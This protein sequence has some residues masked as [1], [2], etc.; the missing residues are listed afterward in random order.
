MKRTRSSFGRLSLLGITLCA[1][2]LGTVHC[3]KKNNNNGGGNMNGPGD[4]SHRPTVDLRDAL[5]LLSTDT[6]S[7]TKLALMKRH[8]E[9]VEKLK[10]PVPKFDAVDDENQLAGL[11]LADVPFT[12]DGDPF[13][14]PGDEQPG[15]A[16]DAAATTGTG[17]T[18]GTSSASTPSSSGQLQKI[19]KTSGNIETAMTDSADNSNNMGGGKQALPKIITIAVSPTNDLYLQFDQAFIYRDTSGASNAYDMASG[20]QCQIFHV[21]GGTLSQLM[22]SAPS[23]E[24]LECIDNMHFINSW[25]TSS[26]QVFQF[27]AD[28][29]VYYPGTLP[30]GGKT[31]VYKLKRGGPYDGSATTEV[32]NAEVCVQDFM[33][34][35]LGGVFYTGNTCTGGNNMGGG[36]NSGYFRYVAPGANASLVDIA[37]DWYQFIFNP[38]IDS[39]NSVKYDYASFFGPDPT[40]GTTP[41]WGDACLF[42]FDSSQKTAATRTTPL[43]SCGASNDIWSW[44]QMNRPS[45]IANYG[46]N[47]A[48]FGCQGCGGCQFNAATSV[49]NKTGWVTEMTSRCESKDKVFAGGGSQLSAIKQTSDGDKIWVIG[50]I[51]LKS[52]GYMSCNVNIMGPHCVIN[53]VPYIYTVDSTTKLSTTTPYTAATCAAVPNA[54]WVDSGNCNGN[55]STSVQCFADRDWICDATSTNAN[56]VNP[57]NG[58]CNHVISDGSYGNP[59]NAGKGKCYL[60]TDHTN[61]LAAFTDYNSCFQGAANAS[62][63]NWV[64]YNPDTKWYNGIVGPICKDTDYAMSQSAKLTNPTAAQAKQAE[65]DAR[66]AWNQSLNRI[67]YANATLQ[68]NGTK[69]PSYF[70]INGFNCS[71]SADSSSGGGGGNGN[72]TSEY[73]SLAVVDKVNKNLVMLSLPNEQAINLW[74]VNDKPYYSSFDHASGQYMLNT[75]EEDAAGS[76][77]CV[78]LS[79]TNATSCATSPLSWIGTRRECQNTTF[80]DQPTCAKAGLTWKTVHATTILSNFEIYNVAAGGTADQIYADGLDFSNNSYK[81]GTISLSKKTLSLKTGLTGTLK[82]IVILPH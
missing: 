18:S 62:S 51:Q 40:K 33:V 5:G 58:D 27:D 34:T 25:G 22:T 78:D 77:T 64:N 37:N 12:L 7:S 21:K 31:V 52:Q 73:K 23:A 68:T 26:N 14:F 54:I 47:N 24:N 10:L 38:Y 4:Q 9:T 8:N 79:Q 1:V 46:C 41:S 74:V 44:I 63:R 57:T 55:Q 43:L 70:M 65:D 66:Q 28:G 53:S 56:T 2:G 16:L 30:N 39:S 67:S 80:T 81:F 50:A 6:S 71:Q 15:L 36:G 76:G 75:I 17:T 48:Y 35:K 60:S 13:Y 42:K 49:W 20:Y 11:G 29:N 69:V 45:D 72:W 59:G 3:N 61:A 19:N 32:I 82:T